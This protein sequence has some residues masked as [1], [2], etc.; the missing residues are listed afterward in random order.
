MEHSQVIIRLREGRL[1]RTRTVAGSWIR[2]W[3]NSAARRREKTSSQN[4]DG[5]I[6]AERKSQTHATVIEKVAGKQRQQDKDYRAMRPCG[7]IGTITTTIQMT[8][9]SDDDPFLP[10]KWKTALRRISLP[11]PVNNNFKAPQ[12]V[13]TAVKTW[14]QML[15]DWFSWKMTSFLLWFHSVYVRDHEKRKYVFKVWFRRNSLKIKN[16]IEIFYCSLN[17]YTPNR[18]IF[19]GEKG[20]TW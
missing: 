19:E 1:S 20:Q 2:L 13:P 15:Y 3:G 12:Q 4:F 11:S 14:D 8:V 10:E 9:K 7:K 5:H 16:V 6:A 18:L 17:Y